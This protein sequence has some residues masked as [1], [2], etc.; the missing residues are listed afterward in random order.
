M[1][2]KNIYI[3]SLS[4]PI[5]GKY[6]FE[7]T[8]L[9]I[10]YG[11]KYG[12]IGKNGIGKSTLLK[13][14]NKLKSNVQV[15]FVEQ[16]VALNNTTVIDTILNANVERQS[17]I[18]E[19]ESLNTNNTN[20]DM[21]KYNELHELATTLQI[22][23]DESIIKRI[24]CGLGFSIEDYDRPT[25]EFS[26]GWLMRI[27]LAKALYIEP[28]LLLLDEPDNH[29]DLNAMIWLSNYLT[30]YKKSIV[31]VSH[32][33]LFLNEVCTDIIN[34]ENAK[35]VYYKGNYDKFQEMYDQHVKENDKNWKKLMS[36]IKS[37][38]NITLKEKEN[39]IAQSK[40]HKPINKKQNSN[41]LIFQKPN[42]INGTILE[43]EHISF[44]Y[45]NKKIFE[46]LNF[47][48]DMDSKIAVVGPNGVGKTTFIK[49]LG[50][51]IKPSS[52]N[53]IKDHRLRIGY[54]SQHFAEVLP[55]D[56]YI[57]SY[58][59]DRY[60]EYNKDAPDDGNQYI[61]KLLGTIGL[62]SKLHK[63]KIGELSGG[64]KSRVALVSL[65]VMRPHILLL[66]EPTNHLD[67][68]TTEAIIK[69]INDYNGAIVIISHDIDFIM[70]TNCVLYKIDKDEYNIEKYD[71]SYEDYIDEQII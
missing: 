50:D 6:I 65:C 12:L 45:T 40:Y 1:D 41:I 63:N 35:C 24:L 28:T 20:F 54:Y 11:H 57:L 4:I 18:K 13:Y 67:M 14:I 32:N 43:L 31:I 70:K 26:G 21:D 17:I 66:D 16:E 64:Q 56:K 68:D 36:T 52:G 30:T 49:M 69:G 33:R 71:G 27:A 48:L 7:D 62:E 44:D 46:N 8:L 15:L 25:S 51:I 23:K 10:S 22:D 53:Y 5:G 29:L 38:K 37:K 61:R 39:M 59:L 42:I 34:I 19:L 3:E 58:L 60:N 47:K 9:K 55:N 2:N